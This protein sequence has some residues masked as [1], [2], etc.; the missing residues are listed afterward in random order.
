MA[1]AS[2]RGFIVALD[3]LVICFFHFATKSW[4]KRQAVYF[5]LPQWNAGSSPVAEQ[6]S[7]RFGFA[8]FFVFVCVHELFEFS[9]VGH[10]DFSNPTGAKWIVRKRSLVI[11]Q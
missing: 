7:V 10:F 3:I 9:R 6:L 11:N 8:E 4:P 5:S 1:E 2:A